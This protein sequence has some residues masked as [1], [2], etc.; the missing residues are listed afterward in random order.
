VD[1]AAPQHERPGASEAKLSSERRIAAAVAAQQRGGLRLG[2]HSL[3]LTRSGTLI[4]CWT[5]AGGGGD[6]VNGLRAALR[7]AF[8]GATSRQPQI[9][10]T[11]LFRIVSPEQLPAETIAAIDAECSRWTERLAGAVMAPRAL[12]FVNEKQFSTIEGDREVLP[13]G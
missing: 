6:G 3:V 8:P 10:H 13:L 7:T 4:L 12:W 5:D 2:V 9:I 1:A 11:T